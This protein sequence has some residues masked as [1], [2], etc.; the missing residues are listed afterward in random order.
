M[1]VK[2]FA[3]FEAKTKPTL[4]RDVR[5]VTYREFAN[6]IIEQESRLKTAEDENYHPFEKFSSTE[7]DKL[8]KVVSRFDGYFTTADNSNPLFLHSVFDPN[9]SPYL[10]AFKSRHSLKIPQLVWFNARH[11]KLDKHFSIAKKE[12][13]WFMVHIRDYY[14]KNDLQGDNMGDNPGGILGG[15]Q[16]QIGH[17]GAHTEHDTYFICDQFES[18]LAFVIQQTKMYKTYNHD[19]K[20]K[21]WDKERKI[22]TIVN[23][24]KSMNWEEFNTFYDNLIQKKD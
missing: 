11:S 12:D 17:E 2:N 8:K 13:G 21:K 1:K 23:K 4:P 18:L 9:S 24:L 16:V 6:D 22:N 7:L 14:S 3:L 15:L 10:L 19:A 20:A 5:Q